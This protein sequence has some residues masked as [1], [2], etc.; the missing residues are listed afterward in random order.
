M[1]IER[2]SIPGP[3]GALEAILEFNPGQAASHAALV[4]HPHPLFG[5]T[6]HNKVVFRAAKAALL[7]NIPT[8]R[9]NF[10]GVGKSQG[11]FANADGET[12]D[13]RAALDYLAS[14]FPAAIILMGFSFGSAVGLRAGAEDSRVVAL[15]GLG[16]A[17]THH[18]YSF[19]LHNRKPKLFVEGTE[20]EFGPRDQVEKV[21]ATFS[22]PKELHWVDGADHFFTGKLEEVEE[23]IRSFLRGITGTSPGGKTLYCPTCESAINDPLV[24]GDCASVICRRCGTPLENADELGIG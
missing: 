8:L 15:V 14:R 19:L 2:L 3:A 7:E 13:A 20:D 12:E 9:F 16:L 22:A 24:C 21:I 1:K 5:G 4:C 11:E 17:I 10:R 18:D 23:T 6:M